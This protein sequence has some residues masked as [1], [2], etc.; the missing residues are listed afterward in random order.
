MIIE[1]FGLSGAGKTYLR[2]KISRENNYKVILI[3]GRLEKYLFVGLFFIFHP[4]IS[5]FLLYKLLIE[6]HN[7]KYLLIYKIKFLFF[8]MIAREQKAMFRSKIKK[9]NLIIDE[10]VLQFI[11]AIYERKINDKDLESFGKLLSD[12]YI[13]YIISA[14]KKIRT[15]RLEARGKYPRGKFGTDYINKWLEIS[16]YNGGIISNYIKENY[17]YKLINNN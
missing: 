11:I 6:N 8:E 12:K 1:F 14:D 10:G 3:R 7:N 2:K 17:R 16:D 4:R 5:S 15:S 13:I 9:D